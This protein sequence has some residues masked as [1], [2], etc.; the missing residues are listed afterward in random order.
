MLTC[1]DVEASDGQAI[2]MGCMLLQYALNPS[3]ENDLLSIFVNMKKDALF[4]II[5]NDS[6]IR[7]FATHLIE[8]ME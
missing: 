2:G 1:K 7:K 6:L 3:L 5:M 8:K 4:H